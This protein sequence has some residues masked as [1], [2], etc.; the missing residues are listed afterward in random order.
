[1]VISS[2]GFAM[3][4]VRAHILVLWLGVS[5]PLMLCL[6]WPILFSIDGKHPGC[7]QSYVGRR[8]FSFTLENDIYLRFQSFDSATELESSIKEK[9]P[10]KIDIGPVYSVDVWCSIAK[11][12][13][14]FLSLILVFCIIRFSQVLGYLMNLCF[15]VAFKASCLCPIWQ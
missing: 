5:L 4:M 1:M 12:I 13:N 2:N 7:D 15:S 9:C 11:H 6:D 10:F 14:F 3:E 8:E